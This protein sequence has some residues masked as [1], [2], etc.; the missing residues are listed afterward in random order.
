[1]QKI[2]IKV[3]FRAAMNLVQNLSISKYSAVKNFT[4]YIAL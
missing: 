4:F 3:K 1:M 2:T